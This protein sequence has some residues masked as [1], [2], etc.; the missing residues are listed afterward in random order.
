MMG[1]VEDIV[2]SEAHMR[3]EMDNTFPIRLCYPMIAPHL[4]LSEWD[5]LSYVSSMRLCLSS[6]FLREDK[7]VFKHTEPFLLIPFPFFF[8]HPII[9]VKGGN[10]LS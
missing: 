4:S 6:C 3:T 7:A 5:A 10:V 9:C 8:S 1:G 2:K